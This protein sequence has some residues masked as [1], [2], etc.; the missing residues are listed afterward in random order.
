MMDKPGRRTTVD[1]TQYGIQSGVMDL[2]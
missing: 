1:L 2:P